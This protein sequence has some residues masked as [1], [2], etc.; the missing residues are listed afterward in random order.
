MTPPPH[1][2]GPM[3]MHERVE[4]C[5]PDI[6]SMH[7]T[8]AHTVNY[9]INFTYNFTDVA[10]NYYSYQVYN[11][12]ASCEGCSLNDTFVGINRHAVLHASQCPLRVLRCYNTLRSCRAYQNLLTSTGGTEYP[13]V[14]QLAPALVAGVIG[15]LEAAFAPVRITLRDCPA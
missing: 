1:R 13:A 9:N 15:S 11:A 6:D 5:R 2:P 3:R 7:G 4:H 8:Q 12:S 10:Y 14:L